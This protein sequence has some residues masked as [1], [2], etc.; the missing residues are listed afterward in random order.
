[1]EIFFDAGSTFNGFHEVVSCVPELVIGVDASIVCILVYGDV[2]FLKV[3]EP[4]GKCQ[5]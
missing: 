4:K 3:T 1:M 2:S 5:S